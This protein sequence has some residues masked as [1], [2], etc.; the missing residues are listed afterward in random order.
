MIINSKYNNNVLTI[1]IMYKFR[2]VLLMAVLVS[3]LF[4]SCSSNRHTT[5]QTKPKLVY[6]SCPMHSE[7]MEMNPGKCPKC[8]MKMEA[9]DLAEL[10]QKNSGNSYSPHI[11]SGGGHVG[12][13]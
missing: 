9:F 5:T 13:H 8:G 10:R 6:Y 7:V 11:N 4:S 2:I 1:K 3:F 12:H